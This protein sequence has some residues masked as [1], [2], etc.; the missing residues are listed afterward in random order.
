MRLFARTGGYGVWEIDE[1]DAN[2]E[3]SV[4]ALEGMGSEFDEFDAF[5]EKEEF[6]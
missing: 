2:K 3:I 5:D 1:I 4:L 6:F